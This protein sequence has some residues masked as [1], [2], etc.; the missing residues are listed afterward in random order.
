MMRFNSCVCF[1]APAWWL[2]FTR[3]IVEHH[4]IRLFGHNNVY[5]LSHTLI[6]VYTRVLVTAGVMQG[7]SMKP[8]HHLQVSL[9]S[10]HMAGQV[11]IFI[12]P[13]QH[14]SSIPATHKH[15]SSPWLNALLFCKARVQGCMLH[16]LVYLS[17]CCA[18]LASM[19]LHTHG[20]SSHWL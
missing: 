20:I 7:I 10:L 16:C 1:C 14:V 9:K 5:F 12:S 15:G 6:S 2:A 8:V 11:L 13:S 17:G 3:V 19:L 18:A 4:Y